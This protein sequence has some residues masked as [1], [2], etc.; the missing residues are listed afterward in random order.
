MVWK[1]VKAKVGHSS[2]SGKLVCS[3]TSDNHVEVNSQAHNTKSSDLVCKP[4]HAETIVKL[5]I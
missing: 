1:T 3:L 4:C 5:P 2:N